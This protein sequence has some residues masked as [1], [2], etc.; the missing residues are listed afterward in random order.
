MKLILTFSL[1]MLTYSLLA[2]SNLSQTNKNDDADFSYGTHTMYGWYYQELIVAKGDMRQ[3]YIQGVADFTKDE[4][5]GG[6]GGFLEIYKNRFDINYLGTGQFTFRDITYQS[7]SFTLDL[8]ILK[9]PWS[10]SSQI[11]GAGND[12]ELHIRYKQNR[13]TAS[14]DYGDFGSYRDVKQDYY[15]NWYNAAIV[16][17]YHMYY[18]AKDA[19]SIDGRFWGG[20]STGGFKYESGIDWTDIFNNR[21]RNDLY[22]KSSAPYPGIN[23]GFDAT[24]GT[25]QKRGLF[26]NLG[27]DSIFVYY[28]PVESSLSGKDRLLLVLVEMYGSIEY[29][30]TEHIR[31]AV[32]GVRTLNQSTAIQSNYEGITFIEVSKNVQAKLSFA[33]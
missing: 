3:Q 29:R 17:Y 22:I 21:H 27:I 23:I 9:F 8:A 4:Y 16:Y 11:E 6:I 7:L 19:P 30:F 10:I 15:S 28:A 24:F 18:S 26:F 5:E 32:S 14:T 33:F 12:Q 2:D 13:I 31:F 1:L 20:L 25:Q